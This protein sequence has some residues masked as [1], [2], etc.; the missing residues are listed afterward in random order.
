MRCC[1]ST[2]ASNPP[3]RQSSVPLTKVAFAFSTNDSAPATTD[4]NTPSGE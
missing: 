3:S 4:S 1:E 2:A